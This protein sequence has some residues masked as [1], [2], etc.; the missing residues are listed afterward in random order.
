VVSEAALILKKGREKPVIRRHPWIFSGAVDQVVGDPKSGETVLIRD[1]SG[2]KL[3]R[4]AFSPK[5][6]IRARIWSW[7]VEENITPAFFQKKLEASLDYRKSL[8]VASSGVRLVHAESDGLPGIIIDQYGDYLVI[9]LLSA[10]ADLWRE[11]IVQI[12]QELI[13]PAGIYERSDVEVRELEGLDPVSGLVSGTIPDLITIEEQGLKFQVCIPE[14]HKTGFYLDQRDNRAA[15]QKLAAGKEVL[16]C[17]CYTGGFTVNALRG[18][19][20]KVTMID[21]SPDALSTAIGNL[22]LNDMDLGQVKQIQGDVFEEL[23]LL[24]DQNRKFDLI[25]LDPPKF[26]PTASH[27]QRAARGYKDINLLAY[28][29]LRSGGILVSFSCSGGIKR[30][31][32]QKILSGAALDAEVNARIRV[33]LWQSADHPLNLRFPEGSYLKGFVTQVD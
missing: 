26:A 8:E 2:K 19:S 15:V 28:K 22:R 20:K 16:D 27:A 31:F 14:G 11:Q 12:L 5:S 33:N 21:S 32:F 6:Q 7:D 13:Q 4:A 24:R 3:A 10:G 18:G 23:R 25:I 30:S 17:F 9:Q 29:L 1:S